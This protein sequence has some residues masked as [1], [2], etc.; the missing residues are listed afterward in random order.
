MEQIGTTKEGI[1][2]TDKNQ[3][4]V[5]RSSLNNSQ[6]LKAV[7]ELYSNVD[8][9]NIQYVPHIQDKINKKELTIDE[10]LI[11]KTLRN[12]FINK[13]FDNIVEINE[14]IN[15]KSPT[16]LLLR[17]YSLTSNIKVTDSDNITRIRPCNLCFSIGIETGKIITAYWNRADDCNK[18]L[19]CVSL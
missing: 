2:S 10:E 14:N 17:D 16:R 13:K 6:L 5:L 18:S 8:L 11:K 15:S 12:I 7:K 19:N 3:K 9:N 1:V 4:K